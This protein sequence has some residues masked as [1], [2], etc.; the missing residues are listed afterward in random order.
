MRIAFAINGTRGDVQP[1]LTLAHALESRGHDVRAGVPPNL[2]A[3]AEP[4]G[5]DLRPLGPDTRAQI[6]A[7]AAARAEAGRNPL[8][9]LRALG[10]LRDLGWSQLVADIGELVTDA[11]VIV[12]G[13]T[14]EQIALAYAER[15]SAARASVNRAPV[16]VI[17]LHHAPV[18]PNGRVGPLPSAGSRR[19]GPVHAAVTRAQWSM[20]NHA[21]WLLT[22]GRE[23]R[24]RV[25]LGGR[26]VG[27]TFIARMS[28][29]PGIEIQAYDRLFAIHDDRRW[30][31]DSVMRRRPVVGFLEPGPDIAVPTDAGDVSALNRWLDDGEPPIYLGFGSMPMRDP[32]A[33]MAV[34]RAAA[35]RLGRRVLV[36]TGWNDISDRKFGTDAAIV[37]AVDHRA[38]FRRCAAVVHHGGAGTTAAAL[39]AGT[40]SV[41]CWYGSDQPFWGS[42]VERVGAGVALPVR[43]LDTDR[44][45]VA[46]RTVLARDMRRQARTLAKRVTAPE[47]AVRQAATEIESVVAEHRRL[48]ACA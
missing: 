34:A 38:V 46:L 20:V 48:I 8:R 21:F 15:M 12:T 29:A 28:R 17:S 30:N 5:L 13:F 10:E 9:R 4:Y 18:R 11:D 33:T 35:R 40:P 32:A 36:C 2:C 44:L 41:I 16:P 19:G 6:A 26:P 24:L 31:R 3:L 45:T 47:V 27:G 43:R 7:I 14:T 39:R 22:R 1:A 25:R 23:N 37:P 42:E